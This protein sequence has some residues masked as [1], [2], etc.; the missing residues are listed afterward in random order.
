MKSYPD[1]KLLSNALVPVID[2]A[3][4]VVMDV[5]EHAIVVH[6]K[7]DQSPVTAA[8]QKAEDVIVAA[9]REL[10][11]EFSVVAEESVAQGHVPEVDEMPFWL[12]DPLDGTKEFI[13]RNGEFTVNIGLVIGRTPVLGLVYAPAIQRLYVGWEGGG[14]MCRVGQQGSFESIRC[15]S[16]HADQITVLASRSHASSDELQE[17]MQTTSHVQVV[18]VGSSLKFCRIAEGEG[19]VYP[20][21]GSTSEWDTCAGHAV[22]KAAG[23]SVVD[24]DG[25][26]LVYGKPDFRNGPFVAR[27][28]C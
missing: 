1:L 17:W 26:D 25:K 4:T 24:S 23:G 10:T 6:S 19:D 11:P 28:L 18:R 2:R 14:S 16:S 5:Y 20:R 22:L 8:D 12:V 3:G 9:L 13:Q 7:A 27:G 15:R 21:S